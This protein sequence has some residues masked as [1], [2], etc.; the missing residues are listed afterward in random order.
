MTYS[1]TI[2]AVLAAHERGVDVI[3][4]SLGFVL[5]PSP[6]DPLSNIVSR[7]ALSGKT[8]PVVSS[9]NHGWQGT[10]SDGA[11]DGARGALVVGA[12]V[13]PQFQR[14]RPTA[15]FE[16]DY[17]HRVSDAEF[18]WD[19][20]AAQAQGSRFPDKLPLCDFTMDLPF[21]FD[22]CSVPVL[23]DADWTSCIVL[24]RRGSCPFKAKLENISRMGARY[25]LVYNNIPAEPL[26]E[27]DGLVPGILGA[28]VISAET[29]EQLISLLA[30]GFGIKMRMDSNFTS[31]PYILPPEDDGL[32]ART[33]AA[34][35]GWGPSTDLR[36]LP[37]VIAPGIGILSTIPRSHGGYGILSGS[38][39]ATPYVSGC[40][41]LVR[42]AHPELSAQEVIRRVITT[43][44]PVKFSDGTKEG[45]YES[46]APTWQQGS[47]YLNCLNAV[48][49]EVTVDTAG[50]NLNDT[51]FF[52]GKHVFSVT[53]NSSRTLKYI[54]RHE[55]AASIV[56]LRE[57][58]NGIQPAMEKWT[59]TEMSPDFVSTLLPHTNARLKIDPIELR[60]SP[61]T[62]TQVTVDFDVDGVFNT[63]LKSRCPLYSG[64][65]RLEAADN[66]YDLVIP[67]GGVACRARDIPVLPRVPESNDLVY[68]AAATAAQVDHDSPYVPVTWEPANSNA[69]F[70]VPGP[71]CPGLDRIYGQ[72]NSTLFPTLVIQV[73]T[74]SPY[75]D[76]HV[77]PVDEH[78]QEADGWEALF[79]DHDDA[80]PALADG[81]CRLH[82]KRL[83]WTGQLANNSWAAEGNYKFR[84]CASRVWGP[85]RD[86]DYA[87][88]GW[89]CMLTSPFA[90]EYMK[91]ESICTW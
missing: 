52:A 31:P 61:G 80:R 55:S 15:V 67:Y 56:P 42:Q 85:Y 43:A 89:D 41:A 59:D 1:R 73:A 48:G 75:A 32:P 39:M 60:L 28:G 29:G 10:F 64:F 81:L 12:A 11:P 77:V 44:A 78:L 70:E 9:S 14:V 63:S 65:I 40:V 3:S 17:G 87:S 30:T 22:G 20:A 47:G 26:F 88:S 57:D 16:V 90:L 37:S 4:I 21:H 2:A 71:S 66:D 74:F 49:T 36:V 6:D 53:N 68:L 19:P 46:F 50:L 69:V 7:I 51:E 27:L 54:L 25:A 62:R 38:S 45:S 76:V 34:R 18:P 72:D 79:W 35:S 83:L 82:S 13:G 84:V 5:G 58:G 8:I 23:A 86:T 33:A 91:P 24:V